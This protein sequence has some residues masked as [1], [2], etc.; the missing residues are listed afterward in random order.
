MVL[1]YICLEEDWVKGGVAV[2]GGVTFKGEK[3][4]NQYL[5]DR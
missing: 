1:V 5:F 3:E 4:T 2:I